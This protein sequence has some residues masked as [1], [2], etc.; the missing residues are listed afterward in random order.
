M[1]R[2]AVLGIG[3]VLQKDDGIGVYA[4]TYLKHNLTCKPEITFINGGVEGINLLNTF[5]EYDEMIVLDTLM[6]DDAPGSIY[7]IPAKE[8]SGLGVNSGGAHEVGVLQVF[9]MIELLGHTMPTCHLIG[10]IPE[11]ITFEIALSNTLHVSF[12]DYIATVIAQLNNW[13]ITTSM[14]PNP[15]SLERILTHVRHPEQVVL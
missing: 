1:K 7:N 4:T 13:N 2:T 11:H 15:L 5:L 8:L 3:N 10:I 14:A 6:L 12:N 9:E